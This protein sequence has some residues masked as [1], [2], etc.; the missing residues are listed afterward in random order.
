MV[1]IPGFRLAGFLSKAKAVSHC[2]SDY[3]VYAN[4]TIITANE[5][6]TANRP[7][8]DWRSFS[9]GACGNS[10]QLTTDIRFGC[11]SPKSITKSR[12]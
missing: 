12:S 10:F 2:F 1:V 5:R 11:P 7:N 3:A 4:S 8:L 9:Q 6:R